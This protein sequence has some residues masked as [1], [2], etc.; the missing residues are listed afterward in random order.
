MAPRR[1][2]HLEATVRARAGPE[3][4]EVQGPPRSSDFATTRVIRDPDALAR[5]PERRRAE[6]EAFWADVAELRGRCERYR[7]RS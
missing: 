7:A 5:L 4:A 1:A 2:R 6:W 3:L